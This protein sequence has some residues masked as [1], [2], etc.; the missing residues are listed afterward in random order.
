MEVSAAVFSPVSAEAAAA[1]EVDVDNVVEGAAVDV[2][3]LEEEEL[4]AG[5]RAPATCLIVLL[6]VRWIT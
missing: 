2:D 4:D 3:P 6:S 5:A 1:V